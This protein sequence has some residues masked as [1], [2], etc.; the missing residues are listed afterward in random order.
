MSDRR[1]FTKNTVGALLTFSL[2]ESAFSADAFADDIKPITA[3]WLK[4]LHELG[5]DVQGEKL[6]PIVWQ[7][8]TKELFEQVNLPELLTFLDF[9]KL[10]ATMKLKDRGEKSSRP[11]LPEVA[12]LPTR[13]VFGHQVFGLK[14]GCSVVPHGHMNMAT[15]FLVL[16]G[17]FHGRHY[18]RVEDHEDHYIVKPTIDQKFGVGGCST[19]SDHK[20]NVHWFKTLSE[21]GYIFNIHVLNIEE[22][23]RS[24][25]VYVDPNG[26]QLAG[27][28]VKARKLRYAE[29]Y[30]LYG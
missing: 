9:K 20:D 29:A 2:L 11:K 4:E 27:G 5:M 8:K 16:N 22:G 15:A 7:E 24:G 21:T 30:K 6:E 10:S 12:G 14:K 28:L 19:V 25:R 3:Q 1:A 18:D 26:E 13:L 17:E 23:T